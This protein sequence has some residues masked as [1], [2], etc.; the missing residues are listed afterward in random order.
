MRLERR[1]ERLG[2]PLKRI[3]ATNLEERRSAMTS[4]AQGRAGM[5][6]IH[7]LTGIQC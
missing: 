6:E 7:E 1:C 2:L 4:G 5:K 3:D